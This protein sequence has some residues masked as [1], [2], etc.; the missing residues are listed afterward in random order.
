M[1]I[2]RYKYTRPIIQAQIIDSNDK[3]ISFP[4]IINNSI[5]DFG[6]Q[7]IT[8]EA[9]FHAYFNTIPGI[10]GVSSFDS[11]NPTNGG[12]IGAFPNIGSS[13]VLG[14]ITFSLPSTYNKI[15]VEYTQ[16]WSS[17]VATINLYVDTFNNLNSSSVKSSITNRNSKIF[18]YSYNSGDYLKIEEPVGSE[19]L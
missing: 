3:Y 1:V 9:T 10:A 16:N 12:G 19:G 5:Y 6:A 7:S 2:V 14:I 17:S 4:C 13:A 11:W 15:K 8:N 18:E